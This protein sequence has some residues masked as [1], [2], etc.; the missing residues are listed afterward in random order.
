MRKA[1]WM[2]L[3]VCLLA[4]YANAA[5]VTF[6]ADDSVAYP[7]KYQITASVSGS[8]GLA[9]FKIYAPQG[10]FANAVFKAPQ[11]VFVYDTGAGI[12]FTKDCGFSL[13]RS[14]NDNTTINAAIAEASQNTVGFDPDELPVPDYAEWYIPVLAYG[15]GQ[16]QVDLEALCPAGYLVQGGYNNHLAAAEVVLI[17]NLDS[18]PALKIGATLESLEDMVSGQE[19]APQCGTLANVFVNNT[20]NTTEAANVKFVNTTIPAGATVTGTVSYTPYDF[21]YAL[22]SATVKLMQ[23]G[24]VVASQTLT[25]DGSGADPQVYSFTGV[26]QTGA[27]DVVIDADIATGWFGASES[28]TLTG[29]GTITA[30][31]ALTHADPGDITMDGLCNDDDLAYLYAFYITEGGMTWDLGD[32]TGDGAINDDDLAIL[33]AF[34]IP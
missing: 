18:V 2:I 34:Y 12:V 16:V 19:Y 5:T 13:L 3:A 22:T 14:F 8:Y 7:G 21:G 27:A 1:L 4:V 30:D 28:V 26:T 25:F 17:D 20:D 24:N 29:S 33:Y 11:T 10:T 32:L 31:L 9:S 6:T 15:I 23:G